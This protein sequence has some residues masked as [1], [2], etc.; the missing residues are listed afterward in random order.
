MMHDIKIFTK[1]A[2]AIIWGGKNFEV[3]KNDRDYCKGDRVKFTAHEIK[4]GEITPILHEIN[5]RRYEITYVLSN[6]KGIDPDYCVF[7]IKDITRCIYMTKTD[8]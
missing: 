1:F 6:Y 2:D 3:R 5:N 7:G 4:N 8:I